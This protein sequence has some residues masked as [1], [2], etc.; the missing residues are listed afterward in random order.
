MD[1]PCDHGHG[2]K[3]RLYLL[4]NV[5]QKTSHIE[6]HCPN[7][8]VTTNTISD[9]PSPLTQTT[10]QLYHEYHRGNEW[11]LNPYYKPRRAYIDTESV[12]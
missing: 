3:I 5:A 12:T 8:Y 2:V 10:P 11:N 7:L 4:R 6:Q 9:D 1:H